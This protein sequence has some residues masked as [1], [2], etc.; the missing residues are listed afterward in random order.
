MC[1]LQGLDHHLRGREFCE[2]CYVPFD[3]VMIGTVLEE[4]MVCVQAHNL[5]RHRQAVTGAPVFENLGVFEYI[6]W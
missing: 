2:V 4:T 6:F 1:W 3:C 5:K